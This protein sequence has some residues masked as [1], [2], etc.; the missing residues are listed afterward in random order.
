LDLRQLLCLLALRSRGGAQPHRHM[1][2]LHRLPHHPN[3]IIAQRVKVGLV[4]QLGG[5]GFQ[6]VLTSLPE[7]LHALENDDVAYG[8]E[9]TA[10]RRRQDFYRRVGMKVK[11][12]QELEISLGVNGISVCKGEGVSGRTCWLTIWST[13][14]TL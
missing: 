12:G 2:R 6:Y 14:Y 11:V 10:A 1:G 9:E 13:N 3:Q 8:S 5:E 4:T 7:D